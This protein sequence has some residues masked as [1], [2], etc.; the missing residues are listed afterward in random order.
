MVRVI[1]LRQFFLWGL[2]LLVMQQ[3]QA[4]KYGYID[5]EYILR[6]MPAYAVAMAQIDSLAGVWQKELQAKYEVIQELKINLQQEKV[7][8]TEAMIEERSYQIEQKRKDVEKS[9]EEIFGY[10]GRFFLKEK[11][12]IEPLQDELRKAMMKV[13]ERLR[14]HIILDKA[15]PGV[16]Y[17]NPIHDYTEYVMEE[18][19]L[20]PP[21]RCCGALK[22]L[23]ASRNM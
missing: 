1:F 13:V 14:I 5:S 16:L 12:L 11:E 4:Q 23:L 22:S 3:A 10:E 17:I 21:A 18:L 15:Y 19:G 6:K 8:L 20:A 7:L 9:R 2:G